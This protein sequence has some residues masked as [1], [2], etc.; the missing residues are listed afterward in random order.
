MKKLASDANTWKVLKLVFSSVQKCLKNVIF[1]QCVTSIQKSWWS[2]GSFIRS[3][4]LFDCLPNA[5]LSLVGLGAFIYQERYA[6]KPHALDDRF[7]DSGGCSTSVDDSIGRV[8]HIDCS[9]FDVPTV[10]IKEWYFIQYYVVDQ[11]M[12]SS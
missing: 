9:G 2:L 10:S 1:W 6:N 11:T 8:S 3:D 7:S 4:L 12:K 5:V